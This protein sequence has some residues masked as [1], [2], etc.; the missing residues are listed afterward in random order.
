MKLRDLRLGSVPAWPPAWGRP[1]HDSPSGRICVLNSAEISP[2]S[3]RA[4]RVEI[5][6][7]GI[8]FW[9]T[10]IWDEDPSVERVLAALRDHIG[11]DVATL[12]DIDIDQTSPAPGSD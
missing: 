12:A 1:G 3:R 2:E 7:D 6:G 5:E 11:A 8:Q 4:V 9:G 10:M